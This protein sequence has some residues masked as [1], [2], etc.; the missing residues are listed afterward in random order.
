VAQPLRIALFLSGAALFAFLC[1]HV[2]L[3]DLFAAAERAKPARI[4]VFLALS[5]AT[6]L[7]YAKRWSIVL[8]AMGR[9]QLSLGRLLCFRAAG[10]AVSTLLPAAQLSGEPVR[11]LLLRRHGLDWARSISAV[12]MDRLLEA[13]ASA[14]VGPIYLAAF[15]L[16]NGGYSAAIPWVIGGM[17]IGLMLLALLYVHLFR[18]A[19]LISWL[20][21][22]G[23][24]PSLRGSLETLE[25]D[26]RAFV[27]TPSFATS[28][29]AA[30][31]AE[32]LVLAELCALAWAFELPISLPT[33]AGVTV[34]MGVAQL[35][36][37]PAALGSLEATEVGIVS[38]AGGAA[39]LGL[40]VGL[41]VRL[42][43]TLWILVG[44]VTLYVEGL[45]STRLSIPEEPSV[46]VPKG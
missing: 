43:E 5:V 45:I 21:R 12:T 20:A 6:F 27:R 31:L 9:G 18:G 23:F 46:I 32:A 13:S 17:A 15:F 36:P 7:T 4:L 24:L 38:L 35:L 37:I 44:L 28:L 34:G 11:A 29:A 16:A 40:A 2:G 8:D 10:H 14:I 3:G 25:A 30:L 42:R 33:L 41:L 19:T 26:L 1:V 39:P 22:R